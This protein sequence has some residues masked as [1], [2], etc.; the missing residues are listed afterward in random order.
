MH[1]YAVEGR[2]PPDFDYLKKHY[3]IL[4]DES[5]YV[6]HYRM[7]ASNLMPDILVIPLD[8][9]AAGPDEAAQP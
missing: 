5:R 1:C 7:F 6:V 2:Y 4:V 8:T 3:G 9:P